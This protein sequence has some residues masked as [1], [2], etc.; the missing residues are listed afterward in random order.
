MLQQHLF[1]VLAKLRRGA[2]DAAG[3]GTE[4]DRALQ[5]FDLLAAAVRHLGEDIEGA[6]L[7]VP[8]AVLEERFAHTGAMVFDL[9]GAHALGA[10]IVVVAEG[11]LPPRLVL[12]VSSGLLGRRDDRLILA[13]EDGLLR[14]TFISAS[15]MEQLLIDLTDAGFAPEPAARRLAEQWFH[16]IELSLGGLHVT[17]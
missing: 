10:G 6:R 16:M 15:R 8:I 5:H 2:P 9:V 1:G 3:C 13:R 14:A 17:R 12:R 11:V 4:L 7:D